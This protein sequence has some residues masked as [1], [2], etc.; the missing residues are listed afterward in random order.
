VN[1]KITLIILILTLFITGC[2]KNND[3]ETSLKLVYRVDV[4]TS[5]Q[6]YTLGNYIIKYEQNE[7]KIIEIKDY[8]TNM[9][10]NENIKIYNTKEYIFNSKHKIV[11]Y[12]E[13]EYFNNKIN[14]HHKIN[15]D[16]ENNN[17]NIYIN[18]YNYLT[19]TLNTY[20][21]TVNNIELS[22]HSSYMLINTRNDHF[23]YANKWT[24]LDISGEYD[25]FVNY[26]K[27]TIE[28]NYIGTTECTKIIQLGLFETT[29]WISTNNNKIVKISQKIEDDFILIF[30]L[31]N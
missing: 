27:N 24:C 22:I 11:H 28:N 29:Y 16:Y 7:N 4:I 18:S 14:L 21:Y 23:E 10:Y 13:N 3:V 6:S 12:I 2:F 15:I 9:L 20:T 1:K 25:N 17:D 31:I 5:E 30:E 19:D 26:G 8:I